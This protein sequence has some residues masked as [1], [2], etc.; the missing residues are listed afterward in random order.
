MLVFLGSGVTLCVQ[1]LSP[2][3]KVSSILLP[4]PGGSLSHLMAFLFHT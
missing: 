3:E 1:S 2:L 4:A